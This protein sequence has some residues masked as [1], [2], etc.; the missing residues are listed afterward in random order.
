[1]KTNSASVRTLRRAS[2][3][4][5][6]IEVLVVIVLVSFSLIGV[7]GLQARAVQ[8]SVAA[9]DVSRAAL[10][11]DEIIAKAYLNGSNPSTL[12][13][14]VIADWQAAAGDPRQRGL[15]GGAGTFVS[16]AQ[17][18]GDFL[19]TVTVT[20]TPVSGDTTPRTYRTEVR[21]RPT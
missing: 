9:E 21:M 13:A 1:M 11:A 8:T 20:W 2:R 10:L 12:D 16:A 6:L 15:P 3:G 14:A 4:L 19:V 17:P 7:V 18:G 5:S